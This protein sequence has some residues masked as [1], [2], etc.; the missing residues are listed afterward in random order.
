MTLTLIQPERC[1]DGRIHALN[2]TAEEQ[3]LRL[4]GELLC[5]GIRCSRAE[6]RPGGDVERLPGLGSPTPEDRIVAYL[7]RHAP[8]APAEIRA[9][10]SL[11]R[12]GTDRALRHLRQM[13]Q[14]VSNGGRTSAAAYSPV[15]PSRN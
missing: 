4:I 8:A 5:K 14:V 10:L 2:G 3:R 13:G 15:D 6:T 9:A 1:P 12:T 11:S 7:R